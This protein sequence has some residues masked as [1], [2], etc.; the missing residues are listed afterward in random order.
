MLTIDKIISLNLAQPLHYKIAYEF[1]L[2]WLGVAQLL[3][4]QH[5]ILNTKVY[6]N[7]GCFPGGY[8]GSSYAL[9]ILLNLK[10]TRGT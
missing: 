1:T 4:A 7:S 8:V 10:Q 3:T 9:Y 2:L 5:D 6:M